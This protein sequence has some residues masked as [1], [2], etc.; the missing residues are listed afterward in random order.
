M[1]DPCRIISS[2]KLYL[3]IKTRKLFSIDLIWALLT[4]DFCHSTQEHGTHA[5]IQFLNVKFN[6][7]WAYSVSSEH[8]YF[9]C[10]ILPMMGLDHFSLY[11][12]HN[13]KSLIFSGI[14]LSYPNNTSTLITANLIVKPMSSPKSKSQIQV[15]NP[16]PKYKIQSPEEREWDW[17][18]HYN[19]TGH[20]HHHHERQLLSPEMSIQW[21]EKTIHD[22]SWPSFTFLYTTFIDSMKKVNHENVGGPSFCFTSFD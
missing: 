16:S 11:S 14:K 15:P 21:W 19:P 1:F 20:H 8:R 13:Q 22:L 18:W 3:D 9:E 7:I 6:S 10:L 2:S 17:D 5:M 12:Y 4:I